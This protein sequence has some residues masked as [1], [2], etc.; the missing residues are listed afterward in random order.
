MFSDTEKLHT[1]QISMSI[2]SLVEAQPCPLI[3]A[4]SPW[5]FS[6]SN[7]GVKSSCKDQDISYCSL[8]RKKFA[9]SLFRVPLLPKKHAS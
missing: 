5:L 7:S 8:Y 1:V 9:E 3:Y 6:L 2:N 4:G